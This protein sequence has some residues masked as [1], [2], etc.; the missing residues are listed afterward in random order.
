MITNSNRPHGV[1]VHSPAPT[2]GGG[3]AWVPPPGSIHPAGAGSIRCEGL[4]FPAPAISFGPRAPVAQ[5]QP[6]V[7]AAVT[8]SGG[9]RRSSSRRAS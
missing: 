5:A 8:L 4:F 7:S 6:D 9:V 3:S 1:L 2:T